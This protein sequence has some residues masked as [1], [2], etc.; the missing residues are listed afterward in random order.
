[1]WAI[2]AGIVYSCLDSALPGRLSAL[3]P[4]NVRLKKLDYQSA[5]LVQDG[6][7]LSDFLFVD[8]PGAKPWRSAEMDPKWTDETVEKDEFTGKT[9]PT[10]S[11]FLGPI[12]TLPYWRYA[13]GNSDWP[14]TLTG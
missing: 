5:S 10:G 3:I 1:M 9:D 4:K 8:R 13:A 11:F 6:A 14:P 2:P 7:N 12:R